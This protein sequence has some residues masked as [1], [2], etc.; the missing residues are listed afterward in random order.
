MKKLFTLIVLV[1]A[2]YFA[3]PANAQLKFGIKG[4]LNIT[5]MSLSNDVF[6]TSNRTGFFIGPTI[7]FTLPIVGLGIDASA[8][9]DQREGEVNVEADDNTLVSTRLKQK[10]INIPINLRYD[11]GLGSLAAV[12]LAAGPQFGFNVGDKNQSLYKDVAE[13]RLN[14][15]N[16][17]VNVGAGVMLLG[18]LQVG[19]NY[20]IVCGKT[21]EITVLDGAES[22]LRGRSNTWQISAA[23]YF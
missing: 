10:S 12:Y 9:Y 15:S 11:I 18:H 21:G 8:L 17:S 13:W 6:E 2:T 4:G 1:A 22:V 23:Y 19:A 3:V 5:D 7:K 20:N 16:F 14:T